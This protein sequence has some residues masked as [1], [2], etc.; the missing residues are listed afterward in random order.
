M[1]TAVRT[2]DTIARFGGDEFAILIEDASDN[3][4]AMTVVERV[5]ELMRH[6][7]HLE[8]KEV[9]ASASI[10]IA[11]A[12]TNHTASDLLRNA[13]MAM[14]IA[15]QS[16]KGQY[17]RYEARMHTEAMERLELEA[18]LRHAIDR[19]RVHAPLPAD[20]RSSSTGEIAGV[21]ALVRWNHPTARHAL[22]AHL[23]SA[24]RGDGADRAA[25][26]MGGARGV[27]AGRAA[28]S[29]CAPA[30]EA[31]H[32]HDQHL[33]APAAGRARGRRMCARALQRQRAR[34]A[35]PRARDHRERADAAER[36]DSRAPRTRSRRSACA[37][38]ST[39]SAP[40]TH[41]SATCSA[42]RSTFS[43]S[44]SRSSTMWAAAT[45]KSALA[46]A[47][48]ALGETLQLQTI[49]EGIELKQQLSGLQDLGCELGQGF[50]FDKPDRARGHRARAAQR[51]RAA[52]GPT[53]GRRSRP[54]SSYATT[55]APSFLARGWARSDLVVQRSVAPHPS[56]E[57]RACTSIPGGPHAARLMSSC[58]L[59]IAPPSPARAPR[60]HPPSRTAARRCAWDLL[61]GIA[62]RQ[63]ARRPDA[64]AHLHRQLEGAARA[65]LRRGDIAAGVRR[66]C[67]RARARHRG[68]RERHRARISDEFARGRSRRA[69]TGCRGCCTCT[70]PSIAATARR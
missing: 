31:A 56:S 37:S 50:F 61:R 25:R 5:L 11:V 8:G 42:S 39:T 26:P 53:S 67:R 6:P 14:Y 29:R 41:R 51:V 22:A 3:D 59:A 55:D 38:R 9:F 65:D 48:I 68:G 64:A 45:R 49:A 32:A 54:G 15:K 19:E 43:R 35:P 10:G 47:V 70:R 1:Q 13:D 63:A 12:D 52:G 40:A 36:D 60:H 57:T 33:R 18:D 17:R 27:P 28:G 69:T 2:A 58:A 20:R 24:G 62:E 66:R 16:G 30:G 44:T 7:F 34:S 46:R 4:A 21:E 23:H